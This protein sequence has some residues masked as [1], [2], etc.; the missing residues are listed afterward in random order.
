MYGRPAEAQAR[1]ETAHGRPLPDPVGSPRLTR[2]RSSR[3]SAAASAIR[4]ARPASARRSA[5]AWT[6]GLV[7]ET[8]RGVAGYSIGRE[9]GGHRRGA[10]PRG[11]ARVPAARRRR[12]A[13][14]G[15]SRRV[16]AA[17]GG[18]GLPRGARVEPLGQRALRSPW[19]SAGGTARGVLP[20]SAGGRPGAAAGAEPAC[21]SGASSPAGQL[22]DGRSTCAAYILPGSLHLV[23]PMH[24]P[25][26]CT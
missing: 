8:A 15:G 21:V 1:W 10:Q 6:F 18:G 20:Q 24:E 22:V 19:I 26:R 23:G 25:W 2:R 9:V 11:R 14:G 17:A 12:G 3:S 16:S 13:A 7:A 4:G 5:S